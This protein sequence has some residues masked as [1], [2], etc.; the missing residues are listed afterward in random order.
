M[1]REHFPKH[2]L[3]VWLLYWAPWFFGIE[4]VL[5]LLESTLR[6]SVAF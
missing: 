3:K 5:Y 6:L 4:H 1:E 2:T